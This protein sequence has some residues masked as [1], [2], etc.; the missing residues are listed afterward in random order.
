[1]ILSKSKIKVY[2][3]T[4]LFFGAARRRRPWKCGGAHSPLCST[5]CRHAWNICKSDEATA[6][7][8]HLLSLSQP[9]TGVW[10]VP[11]SKSPETWKSITHTLMRCNWRL[12][13]GA[14]VSLLGA[15][16][17]LMN[18]RQRNEQKKPKK[19]K[20]LQFVHWQN[21]LRVLTLRVTCT[22]TLAS[23]RL[24]ACQRKP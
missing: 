10:I 19:E 4:Q 12:F 21:W 18:W 8:K 20:N 9:L 3:A 22:H 1:M 17:N 23:S 16:R 14:G 13:P 5:L 15:R 6:S 24:H 7:Q 11:E 2:T